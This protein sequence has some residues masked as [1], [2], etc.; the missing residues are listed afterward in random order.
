MAILYKELKNLF[1]STLITLYDEHEVLAIFHA[2]LADKLHIQKHQLYLEYDKTLP[3][4]LHLLVLDD[5]NRLKAGEP[6]QYVCKST[7][8]YNSPF[9]VSPAVLIPRPETEELVELIIK[10]NKDQ[11]SLKILDIGT[12]SGAIAISLAK[13]I[14]DSEVTALDISST[15]LDIA[16]Q[17]AKQNETSVRFLTVDILKEMP[18]ISQQD[19]IVSNPPYIPEKEKTQLHKNVTQFEPFNALFVPNEDPLIFYRRIIEIGTKLLK[20]NGKIYFETY[21]LFQDQ[22]EN[23]FLQYGYSYIQKIKDINKKERMMSAVLM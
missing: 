13:Y 6:V 9:I 1:L 16:R 5:L 12:G 15:A 18:Q 4:E 22:I 21:E 23:L 19:I 14:P 10:E 7:Y 17:N 8:F 3:D 20:H 2:Y 11:S